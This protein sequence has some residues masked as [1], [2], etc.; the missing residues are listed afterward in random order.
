[1]KVKK[2]E[3]IKTEEEKKVILDQIDQYIM[4]DDITKDISVR[5]RISIT[6]REPT[7]VLL[8]IA[9]HHIYEG[10]EEISVGEISFKA[11]TTLM[12]TYVCK[13]IDTDFTISQ[14]DKFETEEAF[15]ERLAF[16]ENKLIAPLRDFLFREIKTFQEELKELFNPENLKNS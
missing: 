7:S 9:E 16:L 13:Y 6:L 2:E 12:A 10:A 15:K 14:K 3:T 5:D 1:M 4:G 11:A 8:G